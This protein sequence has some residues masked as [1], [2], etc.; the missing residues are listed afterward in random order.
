[1]AV[2][3]PGFPPNERS[4]ASPARRRLD[5]LAEISPRA[6]LAGKA[7]QLRQMVAVGLQ[8]ASGAMDRARR[9]H[10]GA[11]A[12][13]DRRLADETVRRSTACTRSGVIGRV[14]WKT[15]PSQSIIAIVPARANINMPVGV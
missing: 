7:D 14:R 9:D 6:D 11:D 12:P 13:A 3:V 2:G 10:C 8:A 5:G 15:P 4:G 1:M